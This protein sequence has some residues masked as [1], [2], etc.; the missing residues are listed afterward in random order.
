MTKIM[1][2]QE[3]RSAFTALLNRLEKDGVKVPDQYSDYYGDFVGYNE[4]TDNLYIVISDEITI[5]NKVTW[6]MIEYLKTNYEGECE[7]EYFQTYEEAEFEFDL[8]ENEE[9]EPCVLCGK[10]N[11]DLNKKNEC[12]DCV[13]WNEQ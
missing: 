3:M 8:Q 12:K 2:N 1:M 6:G 7:E 9:V 4:K 10:R 13:D 11:R 5:C